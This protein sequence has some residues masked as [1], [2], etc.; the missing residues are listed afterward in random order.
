M[1]S[2]LCRGCGHNWPEEETNKRYHCPKC[3]YGY[4]PLVAASNRQPKVGDMLMFAPQN[5][6]VRRVLGVH[7]TDPDVI[8]LD[9]QVEGKRPLVVTRESFCYLYHTT[10]D[11]Q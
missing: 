7:P 10:E 6:T 2:F 8:W 5:K 9:S 11:N 1:A 3:G 4:P